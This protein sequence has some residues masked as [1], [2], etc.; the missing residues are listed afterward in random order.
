MVSDPKHRNDR[1]RSFLCSPRVQGLDNN[2]IHS[3]SPHFECTYRDYIHL[4]AFLLEKS[5][6]RSKTSINQSRL[7]TLK[8]LLGFSRTPTKLGSPAKSSV[9]ELAVL[10]PPTGAP[11]GIGGTGS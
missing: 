8:L 7:I 6:I 2:N 10:F 11:P 4:L 5:D 1:P 9:L 3:S